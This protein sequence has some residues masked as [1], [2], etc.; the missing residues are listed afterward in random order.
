MSGDI[1]IF[2][3]DGTPVA[4][5]TGFD[6]QT[7]DRR[8]FAEDDIARKSQPIGFMKCFGSRCLVKRLFRS[9]SKNSPTGT[10]V[11]LADNEE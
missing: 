11:I 7:R 9:Q 3:V 10:Y 4:E 8:N 1:S 2:E 6:S 5:L